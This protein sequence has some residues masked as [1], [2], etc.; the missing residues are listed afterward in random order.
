MRAPLRTHKTAL[1]IYKVMIMPHFDYV[2]F[3]IDS[4]T[5]EKTERL[6][7]LHKHAV[8]IIEYTHDIDSKEPYSNWLILYNLTSLYHRRIEH[9]LVFIYKMGK[10][11]IENLATQRPKI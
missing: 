1:I 2:D 3:V 7:R 11:N 5:K 8:R 6:E 4:A 9:L 10:Y